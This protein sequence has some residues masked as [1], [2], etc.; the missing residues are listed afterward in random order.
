MGNKY[1][2]KLHNSAERLIGLDGQT[3]ESL[4]LYAPYKAIVTVLL[5]PFVGVYCFEAQEFF[6]KHL[7]N[8]SGDTKITDLRNAIKIFAGKY[9]KT[10]KAFLKSDG[11]Q[12]D[13]FRELLKSDF[14]K[15]KNIHYNLG[16]Y[17]NE[18][19]HIIGDTQLINYYFSSVEITADNIGT[20]AFEVGRNLGTTVDRIMKLANQKNRANR[21]NIIQNIKIGYIDFNTDRADSIFVH[22]DNKG[23]NLLFLH[24]LGMIGTCKYLLRVICSNSTWVIRCEYII[25][26]SVWSVLKVVENHYKFDNCSEVDFGDLARLVEE[27][28]SLLPSEFRNCMMH[29]DLVHDDVAYIKEEFYR[30][31]IRFYGLVESIFNG[32]TIDNYLEELRRYMDKVE[33]YLCSWFNFDL[34]MIRWN[35]EK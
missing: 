20:T 23:L 21:K 34:K 12:D 8:D 2:T 26:H 33:N 27:G 16:V 14:V 9:N 28:R 25:S 19:G 11:E 32:M 1:H 31:D 17:F 7:M 22:S 35:L 5:L 3:I 10:E 30:P 6:G 15:S 18:E 24:I 4:V 29:Y 13:Y